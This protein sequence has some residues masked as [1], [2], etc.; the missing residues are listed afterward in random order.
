M[1]WLPAGWVGGG[2]LGAM[3]LAAPGAELPPPL[4]SLGFAGTLG[5]SGS[6]GGSGTL[7][8]Y[9]AG[10]GPVFGIGRL[11]LGLCQVRASRAGGP[12]QTPAGG[13][14]LVDNAGLN[15]LPCV[16]LSAWFRPLGTNSIAR[17]LYYSNQ[18]DLYLS[19]RRLGFS[20]RNGGKDHHHLT[21][22]IL[23]G[24]DDASWQF[25]AV[26]HDR[27]AGTARLYYAAEDT[28]VRLAAEWNGFPLPDS[29]EGP[30]QIANLEGIRPFRGCLDSVRIHGVALDESQIQALAAQDARPRA[31][32]DLPLAAGP[33]PPDLL[34]HGDVLLSSRSKRPTTAEALSAFLPDRLMWSY[35]ED[36]AF[37]GACREAGVVTFQAAINSIAGVGE[38]E[39]QALDLEGNPVVA[40]WMVTFS[41]GKPW[42]WGCNNRPRFLTL[43]TERAA[44]AL[45][46]GADWIQFD[47]WAMVV[48]A[49]GWGGACFCD[50]CMRG[51][52]EYLARE[53]TRE[54]REALGVG[55]AAVFDYRD[56]LRDACRITTAAEYREQR[57]TV[58]L[59]PFFEDFQRRSVRRFFRDLR[60]RLDQAAG[61]PV[62]L[63]LNANLQRPS[64]RS[65]FAV[66]MV[67]FLQGETW[68]MDVPHLAV[69]AHTAEALGTWQVFVPKP[70]DLRVGRR[71]VA[72][73]YALGQLMLV[74]W[75]MY[76][77]SDATGIRPRY[78]GT[79]EQYGDLFAF[80]RENRRLFD[81]LAPS[82]V[83][84]LVVDLDHP[85][86]SR[87]RG[88]CDRLLRAS[89]P[90]VFAVSGQSYYA[91]RLDRERLG[92]CSLV[93]TAC[94]VASL[95]A[96]DRDLL[97]GLRES[98]PVLA[99]N[100]VSEEVLR[101]V[102]PLTVW[103]PSGVLAIP[104]AA[105]DSRYR[106]RL[107]LHLLNRTEREEVTWISVLLRRGALDGPIRQALWHLPGA[108]HP[109]PLVIEEHREGIRL[110]FPRLPIWGIAEI[111][112][113]DMEE[114]LPAQPGE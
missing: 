78:Y 72:A 102:G 47:D 81:D 92:A 70:R 40:P 106:P 73:S 88:A 79:P 25:V 22:D 94:D 111:E 86:E 46:A 30:L 80:I 45:A 15:D 43:S 37:V 32:L 54:Q 76:M 56:Y 66:D 36:A 103:G 84:A 53:L 7:V 16:T 67:S 57:R 108:A 100:E 61:R 49:S 96:A 97:E 68:E 5:N 69:A 14:V 2:V 11:G 104:R 60:E 33:P 99:D 55:D 1:R 113:A 64:Q 3:V 58:P 93:L 31:R 8:E 20:I 89:V 50:D 41:P 82:A 101:G 62:P 65:N 24:G 63:S 12:G 98:V 21:E 17:L 87:L 13:A 39:A 4:V 6:L 27:G 91:A 52:R 38:P 75:D 35:N 42:Y 114:S 28:P 19:G 90:F 51:F 95:A 29:G 83:A 77:G 107:V 10:E 110:I 34:R 48:S 74:P 18:W 26:V 109:E 59:T 105:R 85:D 9:A 71:A 112:F 23:A 44:R